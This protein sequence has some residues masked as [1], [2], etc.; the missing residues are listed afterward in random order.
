MQHKLPADKTIRKFNGRSKPPKGLRRPKG[1]R[2][3]LSVDTAKNAK[4]EKLGYMTGILF[5][6][7]ATESGLIDMCLGRN[8]HCTKACLGHSTG[9]LRFDKSRASRVDKTQMF[10]ENRQLFLE[11]VEWDIG[12]VIRRAERLGLT[13]VFRVNGSSDRPD[14]AMHFARKYP[15]VQFYDYSKLPK[16]ELRVMPN[17]GITFSYSGTNLMEALRALNAGVNVSV[18]FAVAKDQHLPATWHGFPVIDGDTHDLR[19][20]DPQGVVVGLRAKGAAIGVDNPFVVL[21]NTSV[22]NVSSC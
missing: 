22:C 6:S 10:V 1:Y 13:P 18:V 4:G 17:Y 20:L 19:F 16:A 3:M 12:M 2:R 14:V 11:C 8:S 5:L 7:P 21:T 9:H 15:T